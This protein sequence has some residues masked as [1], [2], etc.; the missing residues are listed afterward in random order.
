MWKIRR[1][2]PL[3]LVAIMVMVSATCAHLYQAGRGPGV[4][5]RKPVKISSLS[6][7]QQIAQLIMVRI[8]GYYYS[9]DSDY[10]NDLIQWVSRDQVGGLITFR[11][12]V[13]GT[14]TNLEDFQRMAP[15][16]LLI[17]AD[18]ERGLGQQVAGGTAFPS[19]MAIAA[20]FN[21]QNA[22][23]QGRIT[24]LEAR[25]LGIQITFSP[26]MDVNNNP[27]NPIINFRSY[28]DDPAMVA[29]MGSA[30]IRGAQDY[31]LVACAKHYPGHGNTSTDS[32][33]SLPLIP[34]N[35]EDFER[36]EL[37]PFK[38]ANAVG[39][40]MIMS[41]HIAVPG[42]DKSNRP[43]TQ[44]EIIT[45][46][47]LREGLGYDGIIITDGMEMGSISG[48]N[49][50]GEAAIQALKAGNDI[51]L[52]PLYVAQTIDAIEEAVLDGRI[53]KERLEASVNRVLKLKEELG[54][55]EERGR[56]T[57]ENIRLKVGLAESNATALRIAQE[58]ITLVKDDQHLIPFK[59]GRGQT[60][61][62]ILVSMDDD[63][64]E[65]T[66]PFWRNVEYTQGNSRVK[67]IFVNEELTQSRIKE[68]VSQA[69]KTTRTLVTALVR[70]RMDKGESTIDPTHQKL[71]DALGRARVKYAVVSFGSPYLPNLK[72]IPAYLV[73][74]GYWAGSMTALADALYG[75]APITGR[76]P[77]TLGKQYPRGHGLKREGRPTVFGAAR[78]AYDFKEAYTVL[79]SA[80][81]QKIAPG[82][83]VF[84]A[85]GGMVVADTAFGRH[86]YDAG[87][88]PVTTESIFDLASVTKVLVGGTVAMHLAERRFIVL[89]EPVKNY[90]PA[91]QGKW[92][93]RVTIRH[94]LTHSSG[95]PAYKRYWEL[96]IKPD[97]VLDDILAT[98]LE[99]EPG[100]KYVY[101]DLGMI[102]FTRLAER[103]TGLSLEEMA[104][105]W[106]FAPLRMEHTGYNP[107]P[108][109]YDRIVPTE[110][111]AE[112][113]RGLIRGEVHDGNCCFLGGVTAHAGAFTKASQLAKLGQMM[114]DGGMIYGRWVA[115]EETV[116]AFTTD[117][118]M[119]TGSGRALAWRMASSTRH[120]G[121]LF[122]ASAFGHTGYTGASIW[123]DPERQLVVVL[124][125]NRVHPT[126]ERGGH[127]D[128]RQAFH[129]ALVRAVDS[130]SH[131]S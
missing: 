124:L 100:A 67:T 87:A 85:R 10:R 77:I 107:P 92:K 104:R 127:G 30:F 78:G 119:P 112:N 83:Q 117:Q 46:G 79:D 97:E 122:S 123:I 65:R 126:R 60:L 96:G 121:D 38:A 11:G 52:L 90:F 16:P 130:G 108:E 27:D 64:K 6:L 81:H 62:H 57:R 48:S 105:E 14:F 80:I 109:W 103:S 42:I 39:V 41:G 4:W 50:S 116:A 13:D 95:L 3:A 5:H 76:L 37:V 21:E 110:V 45:N 33:T 125:T 129:N 7:R 72:P 56:L 128:M 69:R 43:A 55:Y 61:T 51:I 29:R 113:R 120:A 53:S 88:A 86:T 28:S 19:N 47:L 106:V 59:P 114:L 54:L 1:F 74:Y 34:G 24:A 131:V 25:A 75:R 12:S 68:L 94:L 9:S 63:L 89:D 26:V 98:E 49:W 58:S 23:E 118:E 99:Y 2:M 70:I 111:D 35:R 101:S 73:G 36:M 84:I 22:Y 32:H 17:A 66:R 20:T 18:L 71:L 82:A 115:Q 8:E 102:L 44:S 31:G 15:V 40:K 91:F 93:D